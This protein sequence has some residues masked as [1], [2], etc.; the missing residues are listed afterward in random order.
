MFLSLKWGAKVGAFGR[1]LADP[2]EAELQLLQQLGARYGAGGPGSENGGG[3]HIGETP[4]KSAISPGF[5]G[6][7][8]VSWEISKR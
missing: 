2:D 3:K 1:L 8:E 4:R 7:G 5:S 6:G